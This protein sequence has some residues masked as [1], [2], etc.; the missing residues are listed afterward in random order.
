V[1]LLDVLPLKNQP[2]GG[3]WSSALL[4]TAFLVN[5][6]RGAAPAASQAPLSQADAVLRN[7]FQSAE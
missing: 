6:A 1:A 7:P 2:M 3:G 4:I 5:G